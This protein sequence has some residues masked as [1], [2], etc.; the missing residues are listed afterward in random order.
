M[1]KQKDKLGVE[2]VV[3][4]ESIWFCDTHTQDIFDITSV[5]IG[6]YRLDYQP[7]FGKM[8]PHSIPDPGD[9]GNRAYGVAYGVY[10]I[11]ST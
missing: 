2:G 9:G 11:Q 10:F 1:R 6:V 5:F 7:L 4:S 8:S 3:E